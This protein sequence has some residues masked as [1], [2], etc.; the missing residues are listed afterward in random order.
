M[1]TMIAYHS[2]SCVT[3]KLLRQLLN[4]PRKRTNKRAKLD[5]L[6]RWGSSEVF[7]QTTAKLE[8]NTAAAVSNASNKLTMMNLL[9]ANNTPMPLFT[10]AADQIETIKDATG[11]YYIRPRQGVVRYGNDFNASSDLYASQPVPNKLRIS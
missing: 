8:L 9:K 11:N 4:C 2:R 1:K 6:I 3:G 7:D 10:T 5:V